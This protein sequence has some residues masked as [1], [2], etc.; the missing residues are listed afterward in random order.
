MDETNF[1]VDIE[2]F[3]VLVYWYYFWCKYEQRK[4]L[5]EWSEKTCFVCVC[6]CVCV[7]TCDLH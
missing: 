5:S 3:K 1:L 2:N 7:C 6:V 4:L